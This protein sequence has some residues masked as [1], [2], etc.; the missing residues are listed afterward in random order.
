MSTSD[1]SIDE[2]GSWRDRSQQVASQEKSWVDWV[3]GRRFA[4][5]GKAAEEAQAARDGEELFTGVMEKKGG[6]RKHWR[7]RRFHLYEDVLAYFEEP[8]KEVLGE[9]RLCHRGPDGNVIAALVWDY[10]KA[11]QDGNTTATADV[12]TRYAPPAEQRGTSYVDRRAKAEAES[13]GGGGSGS[14]GAF[15]GGGGGGGG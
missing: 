5:G 9:V 1:L 12:L 11:V 2:N 6:W 15:G 8:G 13:G 10:S 4:S 3:K 7:R 14:G